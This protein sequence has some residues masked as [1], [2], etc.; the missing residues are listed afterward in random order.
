MK[1]EITIKDGDDSAAD[2]LDAELT[3]VLWGM[4]RQRGG[5][6]YVDAEDMERARQARP[7]LTVT[8]K[9]DVLIIDAARATK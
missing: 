4:V 5:L 6:I 3:A 8:R 9:G 7:L 1:A 2:E